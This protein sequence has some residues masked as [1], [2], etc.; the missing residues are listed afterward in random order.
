MPRRL[1]LTKYNV[2]NVNYQYLGAYRLRVEAT[3]PLNTG[4]DPHVFMSTCGRRIT[5]TAAR[6]TTSTRSP[7]RPT[8]PTTPVGAPTT[9][10]PYPFFRLDYVELDF[11]SVSDANEALEVI[12]REVNALLLSLAILD[13]LVPAE[14]FWVGEPAEAAGSSSSTSTGG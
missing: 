4:A 1:K 13:K 11:R 5:R 3:D 2:P 6:T 10:T 9:G 8:W 14:E 7:A 12:V